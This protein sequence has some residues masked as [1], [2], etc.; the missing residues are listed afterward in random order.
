MTRSQALPILAE[1]LIAAG[2][3]RGN[4][5]KW[6]QPDGTRIRRRDLIP[7]IQQLAT[8]LDLDDPKFLHLD[9]LPGL[10]SMEACRLGY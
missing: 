7:V 8:G 5:L 3:S 1:R 2:Y 9:N 4:G 6:R 10:L